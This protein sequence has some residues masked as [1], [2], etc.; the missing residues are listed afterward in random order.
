MIRTNGENH[1]FICRHERAD[2]CAPCHGFILAE[3][4]LESAL[5]SIILKKAEAVLNQKGASSEHGIEIVS[6]EK[7]E[8][9]KKLKD[10]KEMKRCLYEQF[11]LREITLEDYKSRK[12]SLDHEA[13]RLEQIYV[14]LCSQAAEL[15][16]DDAAKKNRDNIA[17][18]I[19]ATDGLTI[20]LA[21]TLI[22][23]VFVFPDNRVDIF[24]KMR[25][26]C[27]EVTHETISGA[28]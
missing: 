21:D 28:S 19:T 8:Y 17:C 11:L 6:V 7:S 20:E 5:Y 24:W 25:D 10:L 27:E 2:K 26:F 14:T 23:K 18:K 12:L 13:D 16:T 15:Q 4:V 1:S 9:E 3:V 22:E